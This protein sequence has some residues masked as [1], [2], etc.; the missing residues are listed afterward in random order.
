MRAGADLRLLRAAVFAAACATLAAAGHLT[1]SGPGVPP[2]ALAAGW[3]AAFAVA[4]PLAGRERRS[5]PA[6]AALLAAGQLAL[7]CLYCLGQHTASASGAG[8]RGGVVAQAAGLL[9]NGHALQLTPGE[10]RRIVTAAGLDPVGGGPQPPA[11]P[12]PAGALADSAAALL[13][14]PM[15]LGHLLAATAAG[16]LL[17]RGEAALWRLVRLSR[18][19]APADSPLRAL[20]LALRLALAVAARLL[21]AVRPPR[22]RTGHLPP[23]PLSGADLPGAATR[24][25]PPAVLPAAVH[26][27]AARQ[28]LLAA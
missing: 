6:M 14:G 2:W 3:A 17:R 24:R 28:F 22:P 9:C 16:W 11:G 18:R 27:G 26:G 15:L 20:R 21:P 7:H 1:A 10:A 25:G 5:A 4:V 23:R 19:L 8:G 12:G 13:T